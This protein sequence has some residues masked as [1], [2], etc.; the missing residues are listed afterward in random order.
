M[1]ERPEDVEEAERLKLVSLADRRII[2][3]SLQA[4]GDNPRVP[5]EDR[6]EAKTRVKALARLLRMKP[7]KKMR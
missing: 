6:R 3:D 5:D 4:I 1:T 2:L 7:P